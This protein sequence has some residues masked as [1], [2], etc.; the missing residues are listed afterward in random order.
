[1]FGCI[2]HTWQ[3]TAFDALQICIY[4]EKLSKFVVN[5]QCYWSNQSSCKKHFSLCAIKGCT[6]NLRSSLLHVGEV[7]VPE[8]KD[9]SRLTES[10]RREGNHLCT[11]VL[12]CKWERFT[13]GWLWWLLLPAAKIQILKARIVQAVTDTPNNLLCKK[14]SFLNKYRCNTRFTHTA[15]VLPKSA[16]YK[17]QKGI[18][19][20]L[21]IHYNGSGL[22]MIPSQ[23]HPNW[24]AIQ[25]VDIDWI[26]GLTGP[27]QG[28]TVYIDAEVMWLLLWVLALVWST[29]DSERLQENI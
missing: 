12:H 17:V 10:F 3:I 24:L 22:V 8:N 23:H 25:P 16:L 13:Q 4:P 18:S 5:H 7:H 15:D 26:C 29:H 19:P 6:L 28:M 27:V 11:Q 20:S 1:M 2:P 21:C 14:F 9:T